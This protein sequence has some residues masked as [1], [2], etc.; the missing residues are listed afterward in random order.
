MGRQFSW[1]VGLRRT[2]ISVEAEEVRSSPPIRLVVGRLDHVGRLDNHD[3]AVHTYFVAGDRDSQACPTQLCFVLAVRLVVSIGRSWTP[4]TSITRPTQPNGRR[5]MTRSSGA[6]LLQT[7]NLFVFASLCVLLACGG[8]RVPEAQA[9]AQE[10]QTSGTGSATLEL[11]AETY[12]FDGVQ[13]DLQ[14]A[15]GDGNL[16]FGL[17]SHTDGRSMR[18]EVERI[19]PREMLNERVT[20]YFGNVVDGDF[21]TTR[22]T[23]LPDGRWLANDGADQIDGPLLTVTSNG[24]RATGTFRHETTDSTQTGTLRADCGG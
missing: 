18:L 21:W 24:V 15:R 17:A 14:D 7:R 1:R 8:E 12:T 22:A 10:T 5:Q 3:F 2:L 4:V 20:I 6:Q 11:G 23:Q 16:V 9:R 13:C 19:K